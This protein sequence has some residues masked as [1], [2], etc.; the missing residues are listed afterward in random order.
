MN[1][2]KI[3]PQTAEDFINKCH[4]AIGA[5]YLNISQS[6]DCISCFHKKHLCLEFRLWAD[7]KVSVM[8]DCGHLSY[9]QDFDSFNDGEKAF[10]IA[11]NILL[12]IRDQIMQVI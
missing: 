5:E 9:E 4:L 12:N 2:P 7:G 11:L 10:R 1:P 8:Y 3:H 6:N